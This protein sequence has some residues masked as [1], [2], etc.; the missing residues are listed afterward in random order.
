MGA[1]NETDLV[2]TK[3]G[4][5][6]DLFRSRH[7][8]WKTFAEE[9][10]HLEEVFSRFK[11]A[12]LKLKQGKHV[13]F[14]KSVMYLGHIVSARGI[15]TDPVKVERVCDWPV[16]GNATEVESILGLARY[17]RRFIASFA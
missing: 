1:I 16:P 13:L 10:E 6:R 17:Y 15:E 3:V 2:R 9:L 14:Q 8:V 4:D 7:C 11:S 5:L 12:G